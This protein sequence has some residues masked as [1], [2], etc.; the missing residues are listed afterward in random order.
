MGLSE[1]LSHAV[2]KC[3]VYLK[4]VLRG[5]RRERSQVNSLQ[6]FMQMFHVLTIFIMF[7][8]VGSQKTEVFKMQACPQLCNVVFVLHLVIRR[9]LKLKQGVYGRISERCRRCSAWS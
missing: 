2:L 5:Y 6:G 7:V 1:F 4:H 9:S 3:P 8:L